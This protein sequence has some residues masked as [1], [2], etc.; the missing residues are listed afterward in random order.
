MFVFHLAYISSFFPFALC[1][2]SQS[3]TLP[4]VCAD[5]GGAGRF[6]GRQAGEQALAHWHWFHSVHFVL[7]STC[8][9]AE[10]AETAVAAADKLWQALT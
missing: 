1:L 2:L 9:S 3:V 5:G 4:S 10:T 8:S 6:E 7:L